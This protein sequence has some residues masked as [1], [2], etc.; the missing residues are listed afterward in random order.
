MSD[1]IP[2][3]ISLSGPNQGRLVMADITKRK[4]NSHAVG[5][6]VSAAVP[7]QLQQS[8]DSAP[9]PDRGGRADSPLI[10]TCGASQS[11]P[12]GTSPRAL[13]MPT[14]LEPAAAE[15]CMDAARRCR[16]IHALLSKFVSGVFVSA[17]R[18]LTQIFTAGSPAGRPV[19]SGRLAQWTWLWDSGPGSGTVP[20]RGRY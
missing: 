17:R 20:R 11:P 18:R 1:Q 19:W 3:V 9:P 4:Q 8:R 2:S 16:L 15:T 13:R 5:S 12:G 10:H 14:G 7:S 6:A